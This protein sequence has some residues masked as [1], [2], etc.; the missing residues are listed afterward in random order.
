MFTV[1]LRDISERVAI[2]KALVR[3]RDELELHV[4]QRTAELA[5]AND[6]LREL[7]GR[8]LAL[9]EEERRRIAREL[10]DSTSSTLVLA[11]IH[12]SK[13]QDPGS[14]PADSA[15]ALSEG[16]RGIE[17]AISELRT[18]SYRLHPP[19]LEEFGLSFAL[20][21]YINGFRERSGVRIE[22][23]VDANLGRLSSEVEL[24]IFRIVQEALANV[25]R[26]AHA[27]AASVA[28]HRDSNSIRLEVADNGRG[29]PQEWG[30]DQWQHFGVGI[31]GM[32]ERVRQLGGTFDLR[33]GGEG[34][35]V[36]ASFPMS[37]DESA[38]A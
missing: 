3:S 25:H 17:Q 29:I 36:V 27:D 37:S 4:Q 21:W 22:V 1:I 7:S 18:V 23:A 12:L 30:P 34:T 35:T 24:T 10:H 14:L 16:M 13:L 19:M 5:A 11:L 2:E 31:A 28:V 6:A 33:S 8:L 38:A 9:Q 15:A 26:H 20:P 32:R